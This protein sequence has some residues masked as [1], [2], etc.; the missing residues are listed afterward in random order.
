[1]DSKPIKRRS[2]PPIALV[3]TC[4]RFRASEHCRDTGTV[5]GQ[6]CINAQ[7]VE[8]NVLLNNSP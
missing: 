5:C 1:M 7:S 6:N 2:S 8:Y 4:T 3:R